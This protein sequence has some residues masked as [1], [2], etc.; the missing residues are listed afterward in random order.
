V[1]RF[2]AGADPSDDITVVAVRWNGALALE[3]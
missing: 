3:A 2:A 1:A